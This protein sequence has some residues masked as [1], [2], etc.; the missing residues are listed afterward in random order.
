MQR[1]I[2][3]HKLHTFQEELSDFV[4]DHCERPSESL[5]TVSLGAA[6]KVSCLCRVQLPPQLLFS[7]QLLGIMEEMSGMIVQT[8]DKLIKMCLCLSSM[9]LILF[10]N[11]VRDCPSD[12]NGSQ[13]NTTGLVEPMNSN[14]F[15]V[16][17]PLC[18]PFAD[19]YC[20]FMLESSFLVIQ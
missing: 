2:R 12:F 13:F 19:Y 17:Q 11:A 7:A 4:P 15:R 10:A 5:F 14:L 6:F 1:S 8:N 18:C 16:F 3:A 9:S 20:T